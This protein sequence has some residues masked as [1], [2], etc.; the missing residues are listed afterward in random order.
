M[1]IT[2]SAHGTVVVKGGPGSGD[3]GHAGRPGMVGGSGPGDKRPPEWINDLNIRDNIFND[4]KVLAKLNIPKVLYH[5]TSKKYEDEIKTEGLTRSARS[6]ETGKI[7]GV[8]LTAFPEH[9]FQY[10]DFD[11]DYED[12]IVVEI[13]TSKL[14][15]RID[16]EYTQNYDAT[17]RDAFDYVNAVNSDEEEYALYSKSRIPFSAI[18]RIYPL[19]EPVKKG[20]PGS[21]FA[22]H[23]GRPGEVGGSAAEGRLIIGNTYRFQ[24]PDYSKD[25]FVVESYNAKHKLYNVRYGDRSVG[26]ISESEL[27]F[28]K[29]VIIGSAIVG[30][31]TKKPVVEDTNDYSNVKTVKQYDDITDTNFGKGYFINANDGTIVD[32]SDIPTEGH[33]DYIAKHPEAFGVDTNTIKQYKKYNDGGIILNKLLSNGFVRIREYNHEVNIETQSIDTTTFRKLQHLYDT[34]KLGGFVANKKNYWSS[35]NNAQGTTFTYDDF[36]SA[37]YVVNGVLKE[38]AKNIVTLPRMT[39]VLKSNTQV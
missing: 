3:F 9:T 28:I 8:Y 23:A 26:T 15:L 14:K 31:P 39:A 12:A 5:V 16:P 1:K 13:D 11:F 35:T 29:P 2:G 4:P 36:L 30:K 25:K 20:G 33:I 22:G 6:T 7:Y 34:G 19:K 37:K 21:G 24:H 10:Q 32:V 17:L 27:E 38:Y 18:K